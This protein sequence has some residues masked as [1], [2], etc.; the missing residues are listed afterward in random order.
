MAR[1]HFRS[2]EANSYVVQNPRKRDGRRGLIRPR[3]LLQACCQSAMRQRG[4]THSAGTRR[5]PYTATVRPRGADFGGYLVML[6][7][8]ASDC[9]RGRR[10][11]D[12]ERVGSPRIFAAG[13]HEPPTRE[14]KSPKVAVLLDTLVLS[15]V[16]SHWRRGSKECGSSPVICWL[17][18]V[19]QPDHGSLCSGPGQQSGL[20][21]PWPEGRD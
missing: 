16:K 11:A 12:P 8:L 9:P 14:A 20:E 6:A 4:D 10:P 3:P 5:R 1:P 21:P 2:R 13:W 7:R 15:E 19:G 17:V 18:D